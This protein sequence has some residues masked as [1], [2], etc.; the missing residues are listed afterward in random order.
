MALSN[1]PRPK[2]GLPRTM[3]RSN[4]APRPSPQAS[5][6]AVSSAE[7]P[8]PR[9]MAVKRRPRPIRRSTDD[10]TN[11]IFIRLGIAS[12]V[13]IVGGLASV[14]SGKSSGDE[15]YWNAATAYDSRVGHGSLKGL[16]EMRKQFAAL[17]I[18]GVSDPKLREFHSM[19]LEI[20]DDF[21]KSDGSEADIARIEKKGERL[22]RLIEEL[23]RKY[24]GR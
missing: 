17:P 10:G 4:A 21:L 3:I 19:M 11:P 9:A 1:T 12:V 5:A 23:N 16:A 6:A 8:A 13:L 24:A 22:D 2:P 15:R 14:F 20:M 18:S 7:A